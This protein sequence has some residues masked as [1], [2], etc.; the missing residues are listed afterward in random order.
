GEEEVLGELLGE[1][2]AAL[3]DRIGAHVLAQRPGEADEVD[4]EMLEEAAIL[5]RQHGLDD[6]VGYLVDR[7]RIALDD[8]ALADLVAVAVEAGDGV[9]ALRAPVLGGLLEGGERQREQD[10]GTGG[11]HRE[12]FAQKLAQA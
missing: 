6:V 12:A 3:D 2:R 11:P 1:G 9:V 7:D 5:G 10:D 4:A 8:A